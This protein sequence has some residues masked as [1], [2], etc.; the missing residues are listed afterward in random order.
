MLKIHLAQIN[1][2]VGDLEFNR[3]K[4]SGAI[5]S[6]K[7][8]KA[9]LIVFPELAI[10]GY[11]PEDLLLKSNFVDKNLKSLEVAAKETKGI[12]ALVGFVDRNNGK[13][14]NA[15]A[16]L[17]EGKIR[18]IYHKVCL[19]N[20]G[21]FDEKRYFSCGNSLKFYKIKD[22]KFAV[23]ICEDLWNP[24]YVKNL[25]DKKLDFTVNL[26][27]SP[28][29]L[30][31][32]E[33]REKILSSAANISKSFIFYCN[34]VGGQDELI[35][36]GASQIFSPQGNLIKSALRFEEDTL[37]FGLDK[38]KKYQKISLSPRQAQDAFNALCLGLKDY[39]NKNGFQKVIV[40]VSGGI[41]SAVVIAI[42]KEALGRENAYGLIMPSPYTSKATYDDAVKICKN[43]G[44]DYSITRIEKIMRTYMQSLSPV[45]HNMDNDKTEENIQARIRGGLLMA[46]SNKFGYL[47]LNTGNKSEVSCGYCTLYGDMVGGFGIL[48][49]VPKDLVYKLAEYIN[50]DKEV[51][52][53]S[54]IK[55]APS[56]ELKPGQKDSDSLPQ[57]PVLD[58]ILKLYVEED[59]TAKEIIRR[60]FDPAVVKKVIAMVDGAEYKRRQ[61]PIGIKITPKAFGRDRRMPIT[62][63]FL[64]GI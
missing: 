62:N 37:E 54:V 17:A 25:A 48:K 14:Y 57:Y 64:N 63:K 5:F 22:Y 49:D 52:P 40:G 23:T 26:S 6:A 3:E 18:D 15:C 12:A 43:L 32:L 55:R 46:F 35:F 44:V 36:D 10:T 56:A 1:P 7:A 20:Y 39:V 2:C 60:G 16:L 53:L 47:V 31:K 59:L 28:F 45:F 33:A 19:P 30:G 29:H 24:D 4:I 61:A 21:V 58:P 13:I 38:D 41:D 42:A 27:S 50:R 9:D 34:L 11:P 51:I 8:K